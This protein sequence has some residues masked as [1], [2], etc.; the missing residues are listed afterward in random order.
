MLI[1]NCQ[2]KSAKTKEYKII[3]LPYS[4][5]FINP[6]GKTNIDTPLNFINPQVYKL[7]RNCKKCISALAM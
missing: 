2:T 5:D 7:Y 3:T 6:I 1:N 4:Y